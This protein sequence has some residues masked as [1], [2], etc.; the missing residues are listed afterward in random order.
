MAR[1]NKFHSA[2]EIAGNVELA[3]S[4]LGHAEA[5]RSIEETIAACRMQKA[6]LFDVMREEHFDPAHA[7][8]WVAE[9]LKDPEKAEAERLKRVDRD[10]VV[11]ALDEA[12]ASTSRAQA[13]ARAGDFGGRQEEAA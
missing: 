13:R 2:H 11:E 4:L 5:L 8:A 9:K 12:E 7:K 3:K 6:D 10:V 1:A